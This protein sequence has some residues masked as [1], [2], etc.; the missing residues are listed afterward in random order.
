MSRGTE[1]LLEQ[2]VQIAGDP[3]IVQEVLS[4]LDPDLTDPEDIRR[5]VRRVF[6]LRAG[7]GVNGGKP[8]AAV[9][10]APAAETTLA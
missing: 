4:A 6:E 8:V 10:D 3:R 2:L 1:R 9:R 5:V 7:T